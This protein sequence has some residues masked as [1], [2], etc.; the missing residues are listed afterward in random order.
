ML[1]KEYSLTIPVD[2]KIQ[3]HLLIF[4]ILLTY[5]RW[6]MSPWQRSVTDRGSS[7]S[8]PRRRCCS[9][10]SLTYL[11]CMWLPRMK[12]IWWA[13]LFRILLLQLTDKLEFLHLLLFC[14]L[15]WGKILMTVCLKGKK[16][17]T[18]V[19]ERKTVKQPK[20]GEMFH[21][22]NRIHHCKHIESVWSLQFLAFLE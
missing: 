1:V 9:N 17:S 18:L 7:R 12:G 21:Q 22:I 3:Y 8:G 10:I 20:Y 16:K 5:N 19:S 6:W 14:W 13:A 4:S 15:W 11:Q 2:F